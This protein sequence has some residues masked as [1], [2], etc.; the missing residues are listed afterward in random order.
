MLS[1]W[2]YSRP[3]DPTTM[4][5]LRNRAAIVLSVHA[6]LVLVVALTLTTITSGWFLVGFYAIAVTVLS[7][8]GS[9]AIGYVVQRTILT[10]RHGRNSSD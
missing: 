2:Q 4:R 5:S 7:Q 10:T 6:F 3:L 9:L 1:I 8:L